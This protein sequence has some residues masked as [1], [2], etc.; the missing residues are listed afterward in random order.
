MSF[1]G[2]KIYVSIILS[3]YI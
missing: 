3:A 2:T 1:E